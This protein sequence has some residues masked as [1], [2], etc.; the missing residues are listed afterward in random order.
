MNI[1]EIK[2]LVKKVKLYSLI[3]TKFLL[4]CIIEFDNDIKDVKMQKER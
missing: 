4:V 3:L 2:K 1:K